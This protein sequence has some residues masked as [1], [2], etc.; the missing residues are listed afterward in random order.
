MIRRPH[1]LDNHGR[2]RVP[3]DRRVVAVGVV[4]VTLGAALVA[5]VLWR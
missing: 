1:V 2:A 4:V 5:A 3:L